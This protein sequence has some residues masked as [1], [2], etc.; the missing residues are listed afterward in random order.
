MGLLSFG[1][2]VSARKEGEGRSEA[3]LK[4]PS[5]GGGGMEV[6]SRGRREAMEIP[7]VEESTD[8]TGISDGRLSESQRRLKRSL[9]ERWPLKK[10]I[11]SRASRLGSL[12]WIKGDL[13]REYTDLFSSQN[14]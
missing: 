13:S 7:E 9:F 4:N 3:V 5:G 10:R 1:L 2:G 8:S 11:Y 14:R 12:L 6:P